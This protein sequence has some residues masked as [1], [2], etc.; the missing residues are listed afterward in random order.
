MPDT[1][2]YFATNR[3]PDPAAPGGYGARIVDPADPGQVT[4]SVV[5]VTGI[6][7]TDDA[8]GQLGAITETTA[9]GF[10]E[11][12]QA[13]IEAEGKNLLVFIHGFDNSFENAIKRAA[14]VR[15]WFAASG[16]PAADTTVLAFTWPSAGLLFAS[17]PNAPDAAYRAD[18]AM[19]GR[20]GL[21]AASFLHNVL[22]LVTHV[23][24]NGR[25]AFLLAHSMGNHVLASAMPHL[26][27]AGGEAMPVR[28]DEAILAAADEVSTTLRTP[29]VG[30][31]PLR[32]MA[33]RISIYHSHRD[34]AMDLSTSAN[35]NRRLG[36]WGPD[37]LID[38][39][40]Y[41]PA[42]FR[43]VDCTAVF[44]FSG[45]VPAD[46]THQYYR[47]SP[48]VRADIAAVMDGQPITPGL[49]SLSSLPPDAPQA[50]S[51]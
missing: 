23:R 10:A 51:L 48:I 15:T 29:G 37:P 47:R 5:P 6:D 40:I 31:F 38:Q 28:Y 42:Q 30:M 2:V 33:D 41:P 19:A 3:Q 11:T 22:G 27:P 1:T 4:Y 17:L 13:E 44:D 7:L 18:Q 46:A 43:C 9:G 35:Q 8:S 34:I 26:F 21:H 45:L 24:G 49:S 39:T 32:A 20:S 25:R 16:T 50:P 12:V 36:F 14:Y